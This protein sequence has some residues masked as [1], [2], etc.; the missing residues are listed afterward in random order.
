VALT[1]DARVEIA[2][3]LRAAG[4]PAFEYVP[5]TV[6]LPAVIIVPADPYVVPDRIGPTL[7]YTARFTVS[8]LAQ[9]VDN[10]SGLAAVEALID[11]TMAALPDGV[12]VIR[13]GPPLLDDLGAQGSAYVADMDISAHVT[14]PAPTPTRPNRR[15]YSPTPA[16]PN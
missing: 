3:V 10:A 1:T 16:K 4:L 15:T 9:A 12:L 8:L 11:E 5:P 14:G 13:C 2:A 6:S 7:T